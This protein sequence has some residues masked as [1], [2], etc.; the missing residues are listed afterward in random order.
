MVVYRRVCCSPYV[1]DGGRTRILLL[2]TAHQGLGL[3][4]AGAIG[5]DLFVLCELRRIHIVPFFDSEVPP[6]RHPK[7]NRSIIKPGQ[8]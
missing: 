6:T 2:N 3:E 1:F 4:S 5:L 7:I 8:R